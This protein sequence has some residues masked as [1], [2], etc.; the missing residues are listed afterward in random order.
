MTVTT[1]IDSRKLNWRQLAARQLFSE[2][3]DVLPCHD[4]PWI[5]DLA[6]LYYLG[7]LKDKSPPLNTH[8]RAIRAGCP[9][10]RDTEGR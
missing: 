7:R 4:N 9:A 10:S 2:A 8:H 5:N 3:D 1:P 6:R